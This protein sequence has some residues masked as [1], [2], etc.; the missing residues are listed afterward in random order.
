DALSAVVA[1]GPS[2]GSLTLNANGSFTYTPDANYNGPD[3]FT[4]RASDATL[5]SSLATVT[6][7]VSAVNDA[8]AVTVAARRTCGADEHSG[9]INLTVGDVESAATALTLSASSGNKTLVPNGNIAFAGSGA[10]RTVAASA[11]AGRTGTAVVT[12][13]VS[14]G[15]A[16]NTVPLTARCGGHGTDTG[17]A[18]G[19]AQL[20]PWHGGHNA[21]RGGAGGNGLLC[22]GKAM[23][24]GPG[25][26]ATTASSGPEATTASPVAWA[27]TASAAAPA[28]TRPRLHPRPRR[29]HRR[30]D[31][32]DIGR[33]ACSVGRVLRRPAARRASAQ[34]R[35][36]PPPPAMR[37]A[38]TAQLPIWR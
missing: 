35:Q 25:G 37:P 10:A 13:T 15:Q 3:T 6:I 27:P 28:A 18:G 8:P 29:H 34:H 21:P 30:H 17:T 24:P 19:G 4:Y 2:H 32:V 33:G 36:A 16:T 22:G 1:S 7:T 14:G 38:P 9:T 31:P 23:T 26:G 12:I 5:T 20:I 11:V